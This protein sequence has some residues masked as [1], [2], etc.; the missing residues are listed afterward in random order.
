MNK[1]AKITGRS[2]LSPLSQYRA[3]LFQLKRIVRKGN[4]KDNDLD[5]ARLDGVFTLF[6]V[7]EEERHPGMRFERDQ[8]A[9]Q[10]N[11]STHLECYAVV[12]GERSPKR[13][14]GLTDIFASTKRKLFSPVPVGKCSV[15]ELSAHR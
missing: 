7:E 2:T 1:A 10:H 14:P 12:L 5:G 15:C 8:V 9:S 11:T 6:K 13:H 3:M 4:A